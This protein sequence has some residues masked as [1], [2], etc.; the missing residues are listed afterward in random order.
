MSRDRKKSIATNAIFNVLYK[1]LN[2]LFPLITA[3]YVSRVILPE[4]VGKVA[5]AQNV[6][7]YFTYIA[8]LGLPTYGTREIAREKSSVRNRNRV[9]S[10][11]FTINFISTS[12]CVI[13]YIILINA[14]GGFAEDKTLHYVAGIAIILNYIN[15]DWVYQGFEEFKYISIRSMI[16]KTISVVAI[17]IF[18]RKKE[19]FVI[20]ALIHCLAVA[21]NNLFNIIHLRKFVKLDFSDVILGKHFKPLL[22][23]LSS[24]IA[25]ELYTLVDTTMLGAICTKEIVGY[26]SNA[27]KLERI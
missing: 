1:L 4:G 7:M 23:L 10:E 21:G 2:A 26:Y 20:Y 8:A 13:A 22:I 12:L 24:S 16:V 18:V 17:F 6:V 11:L 3:T 5:Y 14:F 15:V 25:I 19:D 27:M 9:F